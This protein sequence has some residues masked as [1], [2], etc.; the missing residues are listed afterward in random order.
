MRSVVSLGAEFTVE[1]RVSNPS[2]TSSSGVAS[3][4]RRKRS[5]MVGMSSLPK[6]MAPRGVEST[7]AFAATLRPDSGAQAPP[8]E[9]CATRDGRS[10][11]QGTAVVS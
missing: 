11:N 4:G 5:A 9:P 2:R 7:P 1:A 8:T 10:P 6:V 3:S